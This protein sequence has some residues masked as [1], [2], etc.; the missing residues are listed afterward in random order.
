MPNYV[1]NKKYYSDL[2]KGDEFYISPTIRY[3]YHHP[4]GTQHQTSPFFS[5]WFLNLGK[6]SR[7]IF[8]EIESKTK[9]CK[10]VQKTD[11]LKD[12]G[13]VPT[14]KRLNNRRR[15]KLLAKKSK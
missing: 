12:M 15:K 2:C 6:Y 11:F 14:Q 13:L 4:K 1:A 8:L 10:I 5:F 9:G 7:D 3:E